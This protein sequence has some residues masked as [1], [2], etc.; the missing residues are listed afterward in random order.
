MLD[1][2]CQVLGGRLQVVG[3]VSL[4]FFVFQNNSWFLK[5]VLVFLIFFLSFLG[6]S[7]FTGL[8]LMLLFF[9]FLFL[10]VSCLFLVYPGF[11]WYG[12]LE[13]P[14]SFRE[15]F[16]KEEKRQIIHIFWI[17]VL[18][19]PPPLSTSAEVNIIH[20]KELLSTFADPPLSPYPLLSILMIFL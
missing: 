4:F 6:F 14:Q 15:G 11:S 10:L 2:R 12:C 19:S 8:L 7:S 18:P 13:S 9:L 5:F 3:C 17:S 16:R 1:L 20:T